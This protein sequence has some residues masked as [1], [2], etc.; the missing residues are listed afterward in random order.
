VGAGIGRQKELQLDE[1][2]ARW[3]Y[4]YLQISEGHGDETNAPTFA[5]IAAHI[6]AADVLHDVEKKLAQIVHQMEARW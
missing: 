2:L 4:A 6:V 1:M 3:A 5:L